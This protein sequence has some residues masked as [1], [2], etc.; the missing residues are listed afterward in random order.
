[1]SFRGN[2]VRFRRAV[3]FPQ[4]VLQCVRKRGNDSD[5]RWL[6]LSRC[7]VAL[8][9][10]RLRQDRHALHC[11]ISHRLAQSLLAVG[12]TQSL[13]TSSVGGNVPKSAVSFSCISSSSI[14][15]N[16]VRSNKSRAVSLGVAA[17]L[18]PCVSF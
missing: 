1:M 10:V 12:L 13:P 15:K 5:I 14:R 8:P 2:A 9:A 16:S 18:L 7:A 4:S 3:A 11:P 6:L 17:L